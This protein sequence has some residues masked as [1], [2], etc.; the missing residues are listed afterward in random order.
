MKTALEQI[1]HVPQIGN[2]LNETFP[3]QTA[4]SLEY[5]IK[6]HLCHLIHQNTESM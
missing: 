3:S 4:I 1:F 5:T 6:F 2:L